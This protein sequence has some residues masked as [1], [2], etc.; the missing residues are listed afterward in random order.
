MRYTMHNAFMGISDLNHAQNL[1]GRGAFRHEVARH[2]LDEIFRGRI[3]SGERL[4]VMK[5][6]ERLGVSST[7]VREALVELESIGI[8]EFVHNRGVIVNPWGEQQLREIYQLRRI[9]ESEA[10]RSASGQIPPEELETLRSELVNLMQNGRTRNWSQREMALDRRLHDLIA[11]RCG[12]VRL[13]AELSR[14][15]ILVQTVREVV[16]SNRTAQERALREHIAI[17]EALDANHPDR[18]AAAMAEHITNSKQ[19]AASVMFARH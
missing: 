19:A 9:L 14:Y 1:I 6:A 8:V 18:A 7:P 3:P 15:D 17:V 4:R 12:S 11:S 13:A 10:T 2:L 5:L 16:G